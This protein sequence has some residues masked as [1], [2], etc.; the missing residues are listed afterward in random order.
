MTNRRLFLKALTASTLFGL[1]LRHPSLDLF[2]SARAD[3]KKT[4]TD[5]AQLLQ[6]K[7]PPLGVH[8][9]LWHQGDLDPIE[10]WPKVFT[11][12]AQHKI[13]NCF[14]LNYYFVDP[15]TGKISKAS[16]FNDSKSPDLEFLELG[17][18]LANARGIK[19][20]LYPVLEIDNPYQIGKIWRGNLNFFGS[21]LKNFFVQY[22]HII[23]EM[24]EISHRYQAPYIFLGSELA[25]LSHNIA[26]RPYWE[27]LIYQLK[28]KQFTNKSDHHSSL[29]YAAHWEEY[30]SFPFWRQMDE[31]GIN[32]YFPL[33]SQAQASGLDLPRQA[34]LEKT[35]KQKFADLKSFSLRHQRPLHLTEFGLTSNDL[36]TA[37]PWGQS[38][39]E[40]KDHNEQLNGYKALLSQLMQ[41]NQGEL[42]SDNAPWLT[43]VCFWHWKLPGRDG[44]PYNIDPGSP[45]ARLIQSAKP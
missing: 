17:V 14:L 37:F 20:S 2:S 3:D 10:F 16:K 8:L 6:K 15:V 12:L 41:T 33:A 42:H 29:I 34:V 35:L 40:N 19:A 7:I 23:N 22:S 44:S 18:K 36:S 4:L 9:P 38:A 21:T 13:Q 31:I 26:A 11:E 39:T 45:I 30:L 28:H 1:A 24:A 43:S 32:S 25:S 5:P 27:E